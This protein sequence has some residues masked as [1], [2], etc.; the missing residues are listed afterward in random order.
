MRVK[1]FFKRACLVFVY[2]IALLQIAYADDRGWRRDDHRDRH[3]RY[4]RYYPK[5]Y[6][7]RNRIYYSPKRRFYFYYEV[8]P[9]SRYYYPS[10]KETTDNSNYLP[11]TSIANMASQGVPEAVIIAEIEKT[12][13]VYKLNSE[14]ITYLKQNG[15]S[16]RLIDYMLQTARKK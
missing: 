9:Q 8:Y 5:D 4:H 2:L 16:D 1:T 3:Y 11:L 12:R 13:S 10:E 7:F 6:F 15:A 14:I